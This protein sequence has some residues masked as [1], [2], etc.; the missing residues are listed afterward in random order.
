MVFKK[1]LLIIVLSFF[2]VLTMT[3]CIHDKLYCGEVVEMYRTD[4]GYKSSPEC[5]V[6]FYCDSIKRNIDVKVTFN[7]FANTQKGE[8][9]CYELNEFELEQ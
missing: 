6:V 8:T 5:H 3:S 2:S 1:L 9:V 7:G 4:A